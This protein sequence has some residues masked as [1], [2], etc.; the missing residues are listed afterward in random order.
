MEGNV[1][2]INDISSAICIKYLGCPSYNISFKDIENHK[3]RTLYAIS[4]IVDELKTSKDYVRRN[5]LC[6]ELFQQ[7]LLFAGLEN[8]NLNNFFKISSKN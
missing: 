4:S 8:C 1:I 7:S 5:E 3:Q 2:N 6:A